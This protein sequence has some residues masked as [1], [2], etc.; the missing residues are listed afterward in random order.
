LRF[1]WAGEDVF[2]APRQAAVPA[3]IQLG[4]LLQATER[5]MQDEET[6]EDL[7]LIFGPGSS[8]GGENLLGSQ[9]SELG[10]H[11]GT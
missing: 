11:W 3:L 2:Q 10:T 4:R 1:R 6:N 9:T 7:Q 5:V 8:L